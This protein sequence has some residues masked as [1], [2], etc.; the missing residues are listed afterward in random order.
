MQEFGGPLKARK[1]PRMNLPMETQSYGKL[2][3]NS[4]KSLIN[5]NFERFDA[6]NDLFCHLRSKSGQFENGKRQKNAKNLHFR[7][8]KQSVGTGDS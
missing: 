5:P 3:H 6:Q 1:W 2:R 8:F 7:N 4:A